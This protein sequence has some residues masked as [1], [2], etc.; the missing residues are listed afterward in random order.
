VLDTQAMSLFSLFEAPLTVSQA[1][2]MIADWSHN[3]IEKAVTLFYHL[4]FLRDSTGHSFSNERGEP[5]TLTAW[6]HVTN[7]C[8]L[9]CHYCYLYKTKE[10][11]TPDVGRKSVDAIFRS[12]L[13]HNIKNI[14]VKYAGGEASLHMMSV[15]ALHD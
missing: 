8:N 4:G 12:A 7:E 10:D 9:R 15:I 5:Q 3:S 14:R 1:R 13:K 6:L 11:M 2:K